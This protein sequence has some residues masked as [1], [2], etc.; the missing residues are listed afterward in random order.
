MIRSDIARYIKGLFL[1]TEGTR[2]EYTILCKIAGVCC[3]FRFPGSGILLGADKQNS[4]RKSRHVDP[5]A[6]RQENAAGSENP[7][8]KR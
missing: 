1:S 4:L 8:S 3:L 6:K 7:T 2:N 5:Q